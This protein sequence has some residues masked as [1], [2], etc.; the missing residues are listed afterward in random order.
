MLNCRAVIA[1]KNT[2]RLRLG[3]TYEC[4]LS[5]ISQS[6][7]MGENPVLCCGYLNI[8]MNLPAFNMQI[9]IKYV[10]I[11]LASMDFAGFM[12]ARHFF[13]TLTHTVSEVTISTKSIVLYYKYVTLCQFFTQ[14][15][16]S[17]SASSLP[18]NTSKS[19][20]C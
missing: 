6:L 13:F 9:L 3:D 19:H 4:V 15:I 16:E 7:L 12:R 1:V 14:P 10:N 2:P 8:A 11:R 18:L 20:L 5:G 17:C